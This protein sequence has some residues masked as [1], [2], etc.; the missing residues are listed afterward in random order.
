MV[1]E[2]L[3]LLYAECGS[4]DVLAQRLGCGKE[5]AREKLIRAGIE[6]NPPRYQR[7][8]HPWRQA[9]NFEDRMKP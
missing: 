7:F 3:V 2:D 8:D 9:N 5:T 4:V 1:A 6:R